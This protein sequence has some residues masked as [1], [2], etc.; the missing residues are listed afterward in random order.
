MLKTEE[1]PGGRSKSLDFALGAGA[2]NDRDGALE[3]ATA[4]G[5]CRRLKASRFEPILIAPSGVDLL[6]SQSQAAKGIDSRIC[7]WL[8][9]LKDFIRISCFHPAP[10]LAY[11]I[12]VHCI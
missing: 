2:E 4:T 7:L 11:L 9:I 10:L 8:Y 1:I 6:Q 12:P 5:T 3:A